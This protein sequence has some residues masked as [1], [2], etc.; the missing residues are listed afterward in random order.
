MTSTL[1]KLLCVTALAILSP[2]AQA[3]TDGGVIHFRGEIVEGGCNFKTLDQKVSIACSKDGK[4]AI[5]NVALSQLENY[6]LHSDSLIHTSV[7]YL[8]PQRRLAIMDVT[9]Q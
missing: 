2:L 4:P 9:Y 5:Y 7:R 6:T 8:D 1:K 3:G